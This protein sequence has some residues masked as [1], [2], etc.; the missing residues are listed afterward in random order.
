M[1]LL[2]PVV[3]VGGLALLIVSAEALIRAAASLAQQWNIPASILGLTLIAFGTSLPEIAV[4]FSAAYNGSPD[5]AIGSVVGSN[6]ANFCLCIGLTAL[7]AGIP[8]NRWTRRMD[9]PACMLVTALSAVL[10]WDGVLDFTDGALLVG[11]LALYL[12][13]L[14]LT[15]KSRSG[16]AVD[17]VEQ[18]PILAESGL[19][20]LNLALVA[21]ASEATI[22]GAL[23]T[24]KLLGVSDLIIG[25]T[26][27]AVGSSL[28]EI[29]VSVQGAR[30]GQTD[31]VIANVIGSNIINLAAALGG[32]AMIT[33]LQSEPIIHRDLTAM[34]GATLIMGLLIYLNR[35]S[36]LGRLCSLLLVPYAMYLFFVVVE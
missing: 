10:L 34:L 17:E 21:A 9:F 23:H 1:E 33:S 3:A 29:V 8:I 28:P 14:Y 25:I 35:N 19:I 32:V 11:S 22:W 31:L 20:L 18:R 4:T 15:S 7:F 5:M 13:L 24:A 6:V 16:D 26:L 2:Y 27:L 36:R 12:L 30:I